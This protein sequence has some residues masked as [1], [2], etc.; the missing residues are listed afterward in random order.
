MFTPLRHALGL[1]LLTTAVL[2]AGTAQAEARTLA[3][4]VYS[5][6]QAK[7]GR[8]LY[9][10][11]CATCHETDYFDGVFRAWSGETVATLFDVMAGTMPQS[12]PGSLRDQE[13][14]DVLAYILKENDFDAGDEALGSD[15]VPLDEVRIVHP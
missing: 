15:A 6:A 8:E 5:K 14:L 13:Y 7:V 2:T 9:E 1:G 10:S 4:A 11:H 12:N 3:D